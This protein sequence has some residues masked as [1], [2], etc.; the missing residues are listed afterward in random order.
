MSK[1]S[2]D[3]EENSFIGCVKEMVCPVSRRER[4]RAET[5]NRLYEA[6]LRLLSEHDFDTVTVEMITEAAEVGKGTFFNYFKNKEGI[7]SYYFENQVRMLT[8]TL[9]A[10]ASGSPL[11]EWPE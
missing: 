9:Q 5:R 10:A 8:E 6:A 1:K 11:A 7:L 2:T 3:S 4:R